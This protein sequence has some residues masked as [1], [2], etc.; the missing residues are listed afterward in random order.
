MSEE[1]QCL[2]DL[3]EELSFLN[4]GAYFYENWEQSSENL[5]S[6]WMYE[7]DSD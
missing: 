2:H 3:A 7:D 4:K 1:N 5:T 6:N